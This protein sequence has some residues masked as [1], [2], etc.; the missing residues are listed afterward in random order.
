M[1]Q[2]EEL[3][4]L[5]LTLRW[6]ELFRLALTAVLWGHR[7]ALEAGAHREARRAGWVVRVTLTRV[8]YAIA[9]ICAAAA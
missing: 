9:I 3:F 2:E 6:E 1:T 8:R 4:R 7:A 5:A